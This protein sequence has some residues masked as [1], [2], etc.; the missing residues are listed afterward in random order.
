[1]DNAQPQPQAQNQTP[2]PPIAPGSFPDAMDFHPK[3]IKI[4][5]SN[6]ELAP[7][8]KKS[9]K[10]LIMGI[11]I[12]FIVLLIGG[13][14]ATYFFLN[15]PLICE[16]KFTTEN[17][18]WEITDKT[19]FKLFHMT[20]AQSET[21]VTTPEGVRIPD[22]IISLAKK[23]LHEEGTSEPVVARMSD[24]RIRITMSQEYTGKG[25]SRS[26]IKTNLE[27]YPLPTEYGS[28]SS[29]TCH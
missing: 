17:I 7:K 16:I 26:Q 6:P 29:T 24:N 12:S 8:P 3:P 22:N 27:N 4:D 10:R 5:P 19:R 11:V 23:Y 9:K 2:T 15:R 14:I 20:D 18:T 1:M 21:I 25:A 28:N 13:G